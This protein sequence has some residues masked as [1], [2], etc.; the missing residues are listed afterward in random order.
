M[1]EVCVELS[2]KRNIIKTWTKNIIDNINGVQDITVA[3]DA[4]LILAGT[5]LVIHLCV[6]EFDFYF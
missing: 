3:E 2:H 6:D 5:P 4:C 1:K